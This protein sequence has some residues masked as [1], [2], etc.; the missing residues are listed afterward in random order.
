[1]IKDAISYAAQLPC[2][3]DGLLPRDASR[4]PAFHKDDE[5]KAQHFCVHE[6]APQGH[7]PPFV[8]ILLTFG[9]LYLIWLGVEWFRYVV[10]FSG[11]AMTLAYSAAVIIIFKH[12]R[13]FKS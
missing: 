6:R 13:L 11:I 8:S 5:G 2:L 12:L 3:H 9:G 10:I 4:W 7:F 1:M